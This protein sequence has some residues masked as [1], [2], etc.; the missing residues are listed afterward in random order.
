MISTLS[1]TASGNILELGHFH[2]ALMGLFDLIVLGG[3]K[4]EQTAV[5]ECGLDVVIPCG[6]VTGPHS[7]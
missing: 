1:L 4:E 7:Y 2:G 5:R 3:P 6:H